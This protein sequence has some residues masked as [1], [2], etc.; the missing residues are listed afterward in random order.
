MSTYLSRV[1]ALTKISTFTTTPNELNIVS[2]RSDIEHLIS[3]EQHF[4]GKVKETDEILERNELPARVKFLQVVGPDSIV[5]LRTHFT[6]K[7]SIK[8]LGDAT[9]EE[10]NVES[11]S[12]LP[13]E[14]ASVAE[15]SLN[16][17][18]EMTAQF[19]FEATKTGNATVNLS[20]NST[21]GGTDTEKLPVEI[22]DKVEFI[23][24]AIELVRQVI[25]I[26]DGSKKVDGGQERSLLAKLDSAME[27]LERAEGY[28]TTQKEKQANNK[29]NT[30]SKQ[31]GA[32]LNQIDAMTKEKGNKK[33]NERSKVGGSVIQSSVGLTEAAIDRI[34]DGRD[35]EIK[36]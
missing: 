10:I 6:I 26:I 28:A 22:A 15:K 17:G 7:S 29:L 3:E 21:N 31:L 13:V 11:S 9:V 20:L 18:E 24:K 19:Q 5:P 23:G 34:S 32:F 27:S 4:L 12:P 16:K 36:G 2:L 25:E 8:N 33:K 14:Q 35:A 1:G 30:A